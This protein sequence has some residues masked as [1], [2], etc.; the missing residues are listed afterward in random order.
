MDIDGLGEAAVEQLVSMGLVQNVADLYQLERH[1]KT[2]EDLERWGEKS[3]ANLLDAIERSKAQPFHRV[4]FALGIRHVGAGVARTIANHFSSVEA[5]RGATEESLQTAPAI[6]PAIAESITHFLS[7][8]H[9]RDIL[10]RLEKAGLAM[11]G[12]AGATEGR[13]AGRT[14]VLTGTLPTLT[15]EEARALIE[16]NGGKVTSSVSRNVHYLLAGEE[17]GSKLERARALNIPVISEA[18]LTT[19]IGS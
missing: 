9:N 18:E 6:G 14:F 3:T 11:A 15:R 17:P 10:R 5:L 13:L 8:R 2:L 16:K 4:L 7:E 12:N 19:M 1:R